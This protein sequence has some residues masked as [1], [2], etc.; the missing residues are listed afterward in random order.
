M[1]WPHSQ[2]F[3]EAIQDPANSFLDFELCRGEAVTNAQGI[4]LPISGTFADVYEVRCPSGRFA[5]KCFTRSVPGLADRYAAVGQHLRQSGLKLAVDFQFLVQGIRVRGQW[6]PVLKMP[7]VEGRTLNEFV[8][9]SVNRPEVLERLR[10]LWARMAR[11]LRRADVAH[12][13]LQ[14]GNILL[15]AEGS[16]RSLAL[17]L[18]DYDGIWVPALATRPSGEVGHANYQHPQRIRQ[19]GYGPEVD[20]FPLL[21]VATA[22]TC[23]KF[24]GRA[25]WERYDSGDNLL[26]READLQA[27]TKSPLFHEL[28]KLDDTLARKLVGHVLDALQGGPESAPLLETV[29]P[30]HVPSRG[31]GSEIIAPAVVAYREAVSPPPPMSVEAYTNEAGLDSPDANGSEDMVQPYLHSPSPTPNRMA[32]ALAASGIVAVMVVVGIMI[33]LAS[34]HNRSGSPLARRKDPVRHQYPLPENDEPPAAQDEHKKPAAQD[35]H[36]KQEGAKSNKQGGKGTKASP[37]TPPPERPNPQPVSPGPNSQPPPQGPEVYVSR[38]MAWWKFE[39]DQRDSMGGS[40]G[41]LSGHAAVNRKGNRK[42]YLELP[43]SDS[44]MKAGPGLVAKVREKTLVVWV[45][46]NNPAQQD[47]FVI[48]IEDTD[49]GEWDGILYGHD[50]KH[51]WYLWSNAEARRRYLDGP[52]EDFATEKPV[53]L[54]A[55]YATEENPPGSKR[56]TLYRNGEVYGAPFRPEGHGSPL[57]TYMKDTSC[58]ILGD[59]RESVLG[60]IEEAALYDWALTEKQV[61]ALWENGQAKQPQPA[62]KS[63]DS[64]AMKPAD[65]MVKGPPASA[66]H[67]KYANLQKTMDEAILKRVNH[68]R[69]LA[70]LGSVSIDPELSK[71]CRKHAKYLV[72]NCGDINV[73]DLGAHQE[74]RDQTGYSVEGERAAARSVIARHKGA[75]STL[76]N[77]PAEAVD[78]WMA[79]FY[80]RLPLLCPSLQKIGVGYATNDRYD[81]WQVVVDVGVGEEQDFSRLPKPLFYPADKQKGVPLSFCGGAKEVPDPIPPG[82][83]PGPYGCAITA[84]FRDG[85]SVS[86]VD[87]TLK[88]MTPRPDFVVSQ[89][90][91]WPSTPDKPAR[92]DRPQPNTV[93]FIPKAPLRPLTEYQVNITATVDG[94]RRKETWTFKTGSR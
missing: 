73:P 63:P 55:V 3:N 58:V 53:Q 77:W 35:E 66:E 12:G 43:Q 8:R 80:H 64:M 54:V 89:V 34:M 23:L 90:E 17:R 37:A 49:T 18:I 29:L 10:Q 11:H 27:P 22:L 65:P 59:D 86:D 52:D 32:F 24:G 68:Y 84:T 5:V 88:D 33:A 82:A 44:M 61:R 57:A 71:G 16:S 42:G 4:P 70:D 83:P 75:I 31:S 40:S 79:S 67:A 14:H 15:A 74:Q 76:G 39:K 62:M 19:G 69:R 94:K 7:W 38:P 93:C 47:R 45:K 13:D 41:H 46:L 60:Q 1:P 92:F 81:D 36:K 20:R 85:A 25:L 9:K 28:L 21:L 30:K 87:I 26:F 6:Y 78:D 56:I 50:S 91:G 2:D 48:R 51:K 72:L